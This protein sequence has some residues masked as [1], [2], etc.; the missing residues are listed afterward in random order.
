M[1]NVQ[2]SVC[3]NLDDMWARTK[4]VNGI[5]SAFY[6]LFEVLVD[7]GEQSTARQVKEAKV[8]CRKVGGIRMRDT[9]V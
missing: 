7:Y 4:D 9:V 8:I 1:Y 6:D 2:L 3:A 5:K